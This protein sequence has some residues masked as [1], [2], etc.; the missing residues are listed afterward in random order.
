MR[1]ILL[2][3]ATLYTLQGFTAPEPAPSAWTPIISPPTDRE[4]VLHALCYHDVRDRVAK[5]FDPDEYAVSTE[6]LASQFSWL[7][8][9]GYKVIGADEIIAANNGGPPLQAKSVL[10]T[11]D[12]GFSSV[13]T[14]VYPLL[15]MFGYKAVI[16]IVTDWIENDVGVPYN[17]R[18]MT[19]NDFL[20]WAQIREMQAS[21]LIEIASHTHDMHQGVR[22]NPQGNMQPAAITLQYIDGEYEKDTEY[23]ERIAADLSAS[24]LTIKEHTDI[25]PRI[26]TWPFGAWNEPARKLAADLGMTLSL[27]LDDADRFSHTGTVGRDMLVSNPGVP[28]FAPLFSQRHATPIRAAQVDLDYVYDP[29]P[30]RQEHNLGLLLDRIQALEISHVFLQA[31]ADPDADGAADALYFPNRHLPMRADLFNRA[32]WQL[33]TRAHVKVFAWMPILGYTWPD[34]DSGWQVLDASGEVPQPDV[35]GEPRLSPYRPDARQMI[36]EIYTDLAMHAGF[37][38]LHFH[39]DGRLNEFED[40]NPAA[41]AYYRLA[42]GDD[43][44]MHSAAED[45][46]LARQWAMLKARTINTFTLELADVV[47]QWRPATKTSRNLFAS[48][49][50]DPDAGLYLAQDFN[51]FLDDYDLVSVMA[52]PGLENA[53]NSK[54]FFNG[55]IEAVHSRPQAAKRTIFEL[56][57]VDWRN[58]TPID[59][60]ELRDTM[61][62]LQSQG[63]RNLAYYPEDFLRGHPELKTLKEGISLAE[64]PWRPGS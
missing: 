5:N 40:A 62:Y 54:K 64:F 47:R 28:N 18:I 30:E 39:D 17:G 4:P 9:Q 29:D 43:F 36:A 48:A 38:G 25:A 21:G 35:H 8:R 63:I 16:S 1:T 6:N 60:N 55:L 32:A 13:Y 41:L 10:L 12:D 22:G 58:N 50:L 61:R 11:F 2:I 31:F 46:E 14:H 56:Q 59:V 23:F 45:P 57:T 19:R 27:T 53:P 3:I 51:M 33:A 26:I 44:S 49:L 24:S 20:T 37:A 7:R 15:K 52:M 34:I 42:L